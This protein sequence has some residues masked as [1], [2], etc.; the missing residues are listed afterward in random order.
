MDAIDAIDATTVW[1]DR[2]TMSGTRALTACMTYANLKE[3][4]LELRQDFRK[5]QGS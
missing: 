5:S 2:L 3:S 1:F 4:I